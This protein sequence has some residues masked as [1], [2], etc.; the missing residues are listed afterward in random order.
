MLSG[1]GIETVPEGFTDPEVVG[2]HAAQIGDFVGQ[3][4]HD[5]AAVGVGE[6]VDGVLFARAPGKALVFA[7]AGD[8]TGD[9]F[10]EVL[11]Q[12]GWC[13]IG[14]LKNIMQHT[15]GKECRVG[16]HAVQ[17][18]HGFQRMQDVRAVG[19]FAALTGVVFGGVADG[20][21]EQAFLWRGGFGPFQ[22][23][24]QRLFA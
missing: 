24:C 4:E 5:L 13:G 7:V 16:V 8:E 1:T 22:T 3:N 2:G 6:G 18:E 17:N 21:L 11:E 10:A 19:A 14:V 9:V 12:I 23:E 20:A 15:G